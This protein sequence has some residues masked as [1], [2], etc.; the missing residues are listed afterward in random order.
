MLNYQ[1]LNSTVRCEVFCFVFFIT[2]LARGIKKLSNQEWESF[3]FW[4][5]AGGERKR[6]RG[7]RE[8]KGERNLLPNSNRTNN[9][10]KPDTSDVAIF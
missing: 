5:Q 8:R 3:L 10:S 6:G 2:K 1:I 9:N 4:A 7:D